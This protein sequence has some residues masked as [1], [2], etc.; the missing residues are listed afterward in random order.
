[1]NFS[2][3]NPS[4]RLNLNRWLPLRSIRSRVLIGFVL[5]TFFTALAIS[6]GI[7]IISY[8][9][10]RQQAQEKLESVVALKEFEL[11]TWA[12]S[13]ENELL[14]VSNNEAAPERAV[15]VLD[16]ARS[17]TYY[18]WYSEAV[19]QRMNSVLNQTGQ[20]EDYCLLDIN[21]Q[22]IFCTDEKWQGGDCSSE[23]FFQKGI[24]APVV[25]LP[26]QAGESD[27]SHSWS[28]WLT[29]PKLPAS[30]FVARPVSDQHGQVLGLIAGRARIQ[31]LYQILSN[32]VGLG[33]T[34]NSYLASAAGTIL[35]ATQV[36]SL[37][38]VTFLPEVEMAAGHWGAFNAIASQEN[39]AGVYPGLSGNQVLGVYHWLEDY[40]I[41]VAGEQDMDEVL[42]SMRV[43]VVVSLGI[44][45]VALTFAIATSVVISKGIT[46]PL[47]Q[48]VDTASKIAGGDLEREAPVLEDD[49]IGTLAQAFNSM[50]TQLRDLINN[51]ELRVYDRTQA[52]QNANQA[53]SRR[54]RQ[55]EASAEVGRK[56]TSILTLDDLLAQVV[57]LIRDTFNYSHVRVFLIEKDQLVLKAFTPGT[58]IGQRIVPLKETSLNSEAAK[59]DHAVIANDVLKDERFLKEVSLPTIRSELAIPLHIGNQVLGT[60]DVLSMESGAFID[61][62]ILVI[63]SL[64][65]QVAI[66]IENTALYKRSREL[67]V[68]EERGRLARDLH[69]SVLQSLYSLNLMAEGW[70]RKVR[71]GERDGVEAYFDRTGE[72][73]RQSLKE[74]RLLVYE[75]RPSTLE[76]EGLPGAL[77]RR[78]DTVEKRAGVMTNLKVDEQMELPKA[79]ENCLYHI[80]LEALNNA[81]KYSGASQINVLLRAEKNEEKVV[82][83][84]LVQMDIEDNGC[85]FDV[86]DSNCLGGMGLSNMQQRAVEIGGNFEIHSLP[87][88]GTRI[89]VVI[90]MTEH[91]AENQSI[92]TMKEVSLDREDEVS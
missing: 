46:N 60:L 33:K 50:T 39:K 18:E 71:A 27:Q 8:F 2:K 43:S 14:V 1:M 61:E 10:G 72:I 5:L 79:V 59:L 11:M 91:P 73:A 31:K 35:V 17:N 86:T 38:I 63:Q 82:G 49:E 64:G 65:D 22:I 88:Q 15:I 57:V 89:R 37:K 3:A 69:D 40:G 51:L 87:G 75:L 77:K 45:F 7:S 32:Q 12:E 34:G 4:N 24:V 9:N 47:V 23:A 48:L 92:S 36:R 76:W 68:L 70:R 41:T 67:A 29:D 80:A 84:R 44:A 78:L 21:G 56:I 16:L 26:L 74:M 83:D 30:V 28:C 6:V 13:L 58:P 42:A 66:A 52:F 53:L 20:F 19:R 54:A 85:G 25:E 81:L 55:L 90:R 62:E